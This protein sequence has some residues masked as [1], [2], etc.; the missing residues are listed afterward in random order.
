MG[1]DMRNQDNSTRVINNSENKIKH[2]KFHFSINKLSLKKK[3]MVYLSPS[4]L[5]TVFVIILI[6][7]QYQSL[8][9]NQKMLEEINITENKIFD[10][11]WKTYELS[12]QETKFKE[13]TPDNYSLRLM[14]EEYEL[15]E[16]NIESINTVLLN[17]NNLKIVDYE[18]TKNMIEDFTNINNLLINKINQTYISVT[19]RKNQDG[20]EVK[21]YNIDGQIDTQNSLIN[22]ALAK[23]INITTIYKQALSNSI[24]HLNNVIYY[25]IIAI[26]IVL[27]F[28]VI[29]ASQLISKA[30]IK[31]ISDINDK[32]NSMANGDLK[33]NFDSV[34]KD[35]IG[36]IKE[37]L[38][39]MREGIGQLILNIKD[40]NKRIIQF[41]E[42]LLNHSNLSDDFSNKIENSIGLIT[43]NI[44]QQNISIA[45]LSASSQEL[46]ASIQQITSSIEIVSDKTELLNNLSTKGFRQTELISNQ[47]SSISSS[48]EGLKI[49]TNQLLD[50]IDLITDITN[51]INNIA[52]STKI[53]SLNASIEASRAGEAGK[54]FEVVATEVRELAIKTNELSKE[55]NRIITETQLNAKNTDSSVN[56][57]VNDV[58]EGIEISENAL[59]TFKDMTL[60][61]TNLKNQIEEINYGIKQINKA[62]EDNVKSINEL[63]VNAE[64]LSKGS[65]DVYDNSKEQSGI[66]QNLKLDAEKL[67]TISK[68]LQTS[69][70]FFEC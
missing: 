59:S 66:A 14:Q 42:Q 23:G 26:G 7:F 50:N 35:E 52:N 17:F 21:V 9:D 62:T 67:K 1:E 6:F 68:E 20:S 55:I 12:L 13:K 4:L 2:K 39:V 34:N 56:I 63:F 30:T 24:E 51:E 65:N 25:L 38:L 60:N 32:L 31:S 46:S 43:V 11:G 61:I 37:N 19:E 5:F 28:S 40:N 69:A 49:F 27:L 15:I 47:M 8:M 58:N 18:E 29:I 64:Q 44:E 10:V 36:S 53:L 48:I 3:I 22:V 57:S 54:G 16:N 33:I 70:D 41:S 45:D